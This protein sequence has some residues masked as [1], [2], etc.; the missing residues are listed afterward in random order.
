MRD[1]NSTAKG[2]I[3]RSKYRSI[4]PYRQKY[5]PML[6]HFVTV[7]NYF[8]SIQ[9]SRIVTTQISLVA[10]CREIFAEII[11]VEVILRLLKLY[12]LRFLIL[13]QGVLRITQLY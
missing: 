4:G 2:A 13:N 7:S 11:K 5:A 9:L 6:H 3:L 1:F 8:L 10:Q 12:N